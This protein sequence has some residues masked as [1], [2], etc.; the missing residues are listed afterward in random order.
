VKAIILAAGFGTRLRPLTDT[1]AKPLIDVCGRPILDHIVDK[2]EVLAG[3]DEIIVVCNQR[4][5]SDFQS[6]ERARTSNV[7]IRVVNDGTT[8]NETRRGAMGDVRF[9]LEGIDGTPEVLL[10]GGDN[11]FTFDLHPLLDCYRQKGNSI[12]VRDVLSRDLAKLYGTV[13]MTPE[14]RVTGLIEK[15]DNPH[16][17]MVSICIYAYGP[18]LRSRLEEYASQGH[19]LDTTGQFASWL[20]TVES[21]HGCC[22][23]GIWFDI[24]DAKSL[25]AARDAF[26]GHA[27][28]RS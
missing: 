26:A 17:T 18:S 6:W 14:G 15:P 9:V 27:H 4:F 22:L 23:E 2:V 10:V 13:E 25:A 24:G 12:A 8:S 3:I 7:P 1:T 28:A 5:Y 11:I 20:C 21:V 19:S 16:T